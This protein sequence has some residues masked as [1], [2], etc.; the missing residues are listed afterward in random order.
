MPF[1]DAGHTVDFLGV[2]LISAG[3]GLRMVSL[4]PEQLPVVGALARDLEVEPL[5]RVVVLGRAGRET[6][7]ML[8]VVA[9]DEVLE[10]GAGLPEG[11]VR[12]GI[13][14]G[15]DAA[16]GID[17]EIFG[18]FDVREG[19]RVYLVGKAEFTEQ[20]GDFGR[21]GADFTPDLDGLELR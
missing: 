8:R 12:V 21:V 15:G 16:I 19:D 14:D 2:A 9:F 18:L 13:M 10:N 11:D 1:Q 6:E 17:G 4:E 7:A 3:H 5:L 20:D